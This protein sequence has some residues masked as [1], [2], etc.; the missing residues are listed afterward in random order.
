MRRQHKGEKGDPIHSR[1][2]LRNQET[3]KRKVIK[4]KDPGSLARP[5]ILEKEREQRMTEI[6]RGQVKR[7]RPI[8]YKGTPEPPNRKGKVTI[9]A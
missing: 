1:E 4:R 9:T 2:R 3:Q 5:V 6:P 8:N 7:D